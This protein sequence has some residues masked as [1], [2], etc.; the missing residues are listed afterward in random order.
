MTAST[1]PA[2]Q[3]PLPPPGARQRP[4]AYVIECDGTQAKIATLAIPG[5][6]LAAY[7]SVGQQISIRVGKNR[8]VG[9]LYK[10]EADNPAWSYDKPNP[11]T[12]FVELAGEVRSLD[13]GKEVF[14]SGISVY[15]SLGAEAH[16]IRKEDLTTIY[17]SSDQSAVTIGSLSQARDIPAVVSVDALLSRHFAVVGTTGTGKSTSVSIILHLIAQKAKEQR[18]L[19]LDPH[20]EYT[21]AFGKKAHTI[22]AETLDMPFW[23]L[24]LEEFSQVVFRGRLESDEELDALR[25]FIPK[26]KVYYREG[27]AKGLRRQTGGNAITADSPVPYRIADLLALLEEEIGSLD[28]ALRR[29]TLRRLKARIESAINDPRFG[30]LFGS[31]D[32]TDRIEAVIGEIYR[33]PLD[34]KPITVFQMSGIPSEVVNSVASV[35]CRLAF[36]LALAS[37]GRVKTLVVCEEAH[38]YIPAD[39][40][41]GFA[42]TRA[43]IARIAKEGRKYGVAIAI[44][45]Q[46]PN[47]LDPT[48][49]SQCNTIFSLRLGN[50][51]DQDVMRKAISNG[52]RS[53]IAFLSSLA[54]REC[55]AFGA[56]VSTPMRMMFRTLARAAQPSSANVTLE[57]GPQGEPSLTEIVGAMRGLSDHGGESEYEDDEWVVGESLEEFVAK[58]ETDNAPKD[59][60]GKVRAALMRKQA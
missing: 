5:T 54:D 9:L 29:L 40:S 12:L 26:A 37:D 11:I 44:I 43:S 33:V 58:S 34:D 53:S 41:A 51:S 2:A 7:W 20:N 1:P 60:V 30:F 16:R 3:A 52:S 32:A 38:R 59:A 46:R 14:S 6:D 10:V 31:H 42:P 22:T 25:E 36:D 4:G 15:P 17:Q 57:G 19:I 13:D 45:T 47:E 27:R 49:L 56:A 39:T 28:G 8:V 55:I 23:M 24:T 18:I 50:D 21:S 48:I 35:L